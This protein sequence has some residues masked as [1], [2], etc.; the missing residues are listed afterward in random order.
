METNKMNFFIESKIEESYFDNNI[1]DKKYTLLL[2]DDE[3]ANLSLME[4]LL[5]EYYNILKAKDGYEAIALLQNDPDP[6]RISLIITDQKMPK[7]SGVEFLKETINIIPNTIRIILTGFSDIDAIIKAI[8]EGKVYKYLTKPLEPKDLQ[9]T[10]K[11][12]LEAYELEQKNYSLI[13][14]LQ[15]FNSSLEQKVEERTEALKAITEMIVHDLKNP[16]SS[17]LIFAD[18]LITQELS[19]ERNRDVATLI[20]TSG[21]KL[22]K[23]VD[24]LL[25]ISS[26]EQGNIE[27]DIKMINAVKIVEQ[28]I[29]EF[30]PIAEAKDITLK[31]SDKPEK[32]EV[33]ADTNRLYQVLE[34]LVSNAVKFSEQGKKII[35]TLK[36]QN[37]DIVFM[38]RD[39]GPGLTDDDKSK[40][41]R[42]F[43]YL[44]ATPTGGEHSSRVGLSIVKSLVEAMNGKIWCES[45]A[46][47]G[48]AFFFTLPG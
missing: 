1:P 14:E 23:M 32:I 35:I 47:Q 13:N 38:I 29:S 44:S 24:S 28:V 20:K 4:N 5:E 9:I 26:I 17:I 15:Q 40:L 7:M 46:G 36:R 34:N 6:Q 22:F 39:Q 16:I 2:V 19:L 8:N 45:E 31:F 3:T 11:R 41:F 42:K 43:A 18:H 30:E 10:V 25:D 12:A 48:A 33:L 21:M 27:L 37:D